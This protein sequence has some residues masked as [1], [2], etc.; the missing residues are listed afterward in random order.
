M[1]VNQLDAKT[2]PNNRDKPNI[3]EEQREDHPLINNPMKESPYYGWDM[4]EEDPVNYKDV[5]SRGL[6]FLF[7]LIRRVDPVVGIASPLDKNVS[8][9]QKPSSGDFVVVSRAGNNPNDI[10]IFEITNDWYGDPEPDMS[11]MVKKV[12]E[13]ADGSGML[14]PRNTYGSY[15]ETAD[16][17]DMF[18]GGKSTLH[19]DF[20]AQ[21]GINREIQ[22]DSHIRKNISGGNPDKMRD[23][24]GRAGEMVKSNSLSIGM[25]E[26]GKSGKKVPGGVAENV[27]GNNKGFGFNWGEAFK[28]FV[29]TAAHN[30]YNS[31]MSAGMRGG[32]A[33]V[34]PVKPVR[35]ANKVGAEYNYRVDKKN[36]Q[37]SIISNKSKTAGYQAGIAEQKYHK[38]QAQNEAWAGKQGYGY[39][40]KT[41]KMDSSIKGN[42]PG[43]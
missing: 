1:Q 43:K 25:P 13:M 33:M 40:K 37:D 35:A 20:T 5:Q 29:K 31:L 32:Q 39:D 24:F 4:V 22:T 19:A 12:I 23:V 2:T 6:E 8:V 41:G 9:Y 21:F 28:T 27:R 11:Q 14:R 15:L 30:T 38:T 16:L 3:G 10:R 26:I 36:K 7:G 18:N 34:D 42:Y 17:E